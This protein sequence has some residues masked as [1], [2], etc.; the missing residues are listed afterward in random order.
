LRNG[1]HHFRNLFDH[2]GRHNGRGRSLENCI[3]DP[4]NPAERFAQE[5]L[6]FLETLKQYQVRQL[7]LVTR[8]LE[9]SNLNGQVIQTRL[10]G[11]EP[12]REGVEEQL[13]NIMVFK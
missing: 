10:E 2:S 7:G 3:R 5:L 4:L 1:S 12:L 9:P 6:S 8:N 11:T 13:C